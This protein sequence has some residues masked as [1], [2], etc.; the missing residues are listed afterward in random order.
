MESNQT[1]IPRRATGISCDNATLQQQVLNKHRITQAK[2]TEMAR[3]FF[4]ATIPG[5][6]PIPASVIHDMISNLDCNEFKIRLTAD[7]NNMYSNHEIDIDIE[8]VK[9]FEVNYSII[10]FKGLFN[11]YHPTHVHFSKAISV[12][13]FGT[14]K[15]DVIFVA[16]NGTTPVYYGDLSDLLP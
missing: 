12:D 10:L 2:F 11:I 6:K 1:A 5:P 14:T 3:D 16:T 9:R 8:Q 4:G 13:Q 15:Y 7:E